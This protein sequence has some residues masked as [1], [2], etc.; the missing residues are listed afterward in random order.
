M[1]TFLVSDVL[2]NGL[3]PLRGKKNAGTVKNKFKSRIYIR[4]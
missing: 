4:N 2:A 3:A 1:F